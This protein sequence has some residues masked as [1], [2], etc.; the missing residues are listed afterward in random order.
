MSDQ[1]N[2]LIRCFAAVFPTLTSQEILVT[3][4]GSVGVWDS[5]A[6]VKLVAVIE[7][8]FNVQI[9]L[10]DPSRLDSFAAFENYLRQ[11]VLA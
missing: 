4:V 10:S 7:E 5:L 1:R 3:S 9:D 8:E 2:R 6:T 11:R